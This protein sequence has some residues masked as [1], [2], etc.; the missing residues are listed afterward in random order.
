MNRKLRYYGNYLFLRRNFFLLTFI[1]GLAY[2]WFNHYANLEGDTA[3]VQIMLSMITLGFCAL[4]FGFSLVTAGLAY[5]H[6]WL[7]KRVFEGDAGERAD[8]VKV[9]FKEVHPVAGEAGV[10]IQV[11]GVRKPPGGFLRVRLVFDDFLQTDDLLLTQKVKSGKKTVGVGVS[12]HL[13]LPNIRDYRLQCS[14]IYFEDFFHLFALPYRETEQVGLYTEPPRREEAAV[15]ISTD[16]SEDPV[17]KVLQHKTAR[18]ELIDYKKYAPGDDIRRIIWKVFARTR[19]LTVRKPEMTYPYVSHI[20]VLAS[21]YDGSPS[22]QTPEIKEFLLD[23]YKEKLRQIV[24]ALQEQELAVRFFTDQPV[25]EHYSL[26]EYHRIL[27][28]ISTSRWQKQMPVDQF[29]RENRHKLRG[30]STVL[31]FSSLCASTALENLRNGRLNDFHLLFYDVTRTLTESRPPSLI[32]RLFVVDPYEPLEAA[33]RKLNARPT[34]KYILR[35][36]E[37]IEQTFHSNNLA[38]I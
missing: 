8:I 9:F 3:R 7:R 12:T 18:G 27:Y 19:E 32:K 6:F 4:M 15:D 20:N 26:D 11:L 31:V 21:F 1:A 10:E 28:M 30:G 24:D 22:H 35:N 17:Q 38:V 34:I 5:G 36:S 37:R 16:K 13:P 2:Y 23:I 14:F 29:V 33:R 25:P